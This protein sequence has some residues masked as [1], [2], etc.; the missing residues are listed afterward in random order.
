[1]KPLKELFSQY[2]PDAASLEFL[3]DSGDYSVARS[4]K[5]ADRYE[6]TV[7]PSRVWSKEL[8]GAVED[9]LNR[10]YGGRYPVR[11][12]T[13]YGPGLFGPA[14][15]D[16]AVAEAVRRGLIPPGF[17]GDCSF[18]FDGSVLD[19]TANVG[20]GGLDF[21]SANK[22][23][24]A[25]AA[26]IADEFS[27]Q[28]PVRITGRR[29]YVPYGESA[30]MKEFYSELD[31]KCREALDTYESDP[32]PAARADDRSGDAAPALRRVRS[33]F[34][35]DAVAQVSD[36]ICSIGRTSF[37]ISSPELLYGPDF[38]IEPV[39]VAS[40]AGP[41]RN[42]VFTGT[43][44]DIRSD[45]RNK[46][47]FLVSGALFDGNATVALR[48]S[49]CTEEQAAE[50]T[51]KL[52][53]GMTVAALGD[54]RTDT[55][56]GELY[57]SPRSFAKISRLPR[58]DT[59]E[60]KRVELHLHTSMSAMDAIPAVSDVIARAMDWGHGAVAITDHGNVQAFPD[61]MIY[62]DKYYAKH[63]EVP[64]EERFKPIYGMEAYFVKDTAVP[65]RGRADPDFDAPAVVFDLETTGLSASDS[66]IIEI[67]AVRLEHG[68]VTGRFST[69]VDPG[70]P[71]PKEITAITSIKDSDVAGAPSAAEAVPQ[72]LDFCSGALLVAHNA[73]FDVGFIRTAA[74]ELG[75][76]FDRPYLD[77]LALSR[78]LNPDLARHR[79]DNVAKYY[80]LGDFRHHRAVDDAEILSRIYLCMIEKMREFDIKDLAAMEREISTKS[81][82]LKLNSYHMIILVKNATGLKNLYR[83]IS[84]SYL[85]YYYRNPRIPKTLLD[86]Y[87]EGLIIGSA[88]SMGELYT[89]IIENRSEAEIEEIASYYDYLEIQ[90]ISNDMYMVGENKVESEETLRDVTRRIVALADKLGKP[91]VATSDAHFL[92]PDDEIYRRILQA[93]MK[94]RN[95]DTPMPLYFHTTDEMLREFDFLGPEKAYEVVVVNP[96]RIAESVGR[97]RPIPAGN[98]P[99][100]LEG[101]EEE[102]T[103]SCHRRAR[104]LYGD[105]LPAVVKN[106]LD[107]ELGSIIS[108]GFAV[109]YVIAARLVS[110]SESQGYLV[111][112]RG[113]VGS[114]FVAAMGGI[115]EVNALP[116]HYYCPSCKFSD[117]SNP[118]DAGSGFDFP[119]AV[120]PV[121]GA[122]LL[123]D[124][125]DIPFET[126][127]GFHGEK[128]PDIDLNFSGDVQGSVHR[129]TE[130]LFG[131][132]NVFKAGTVSTLADKTAYGFVMKYYENRGVMPPRAEIDRIVGRCMGV[133]RTTG[134]HPGGIIVVPRDRDVYDFTPVQRP[135]DDPRSD[136]V[137]THFAFSYLH[138]TILKLDELGHDVPT[139]YKYLE[140]YSGVPVLDVAMND[141]S[142]YELFYSTESIGIPQMD[143][144]DH[145]TRMLGLSVGTLGIPEMG[146]SFIQQVLMDA[147]PRNFADLIQVSGLTHGTDVW[148][149][150]AQDLIKQGICDI[151]HVVGTRDGIMLDLIRYGV[152]KSMAFKIMEKVRKNKKGERLPAEMLD[153]MRE[154]SVPEW[155]IGSLQKIKYMFPK[156]HAAAYIMSAIR[157]GW[158]KVHRPVAF[159]CAILT[160][161]PDGFDGEI[162]GAGRSVIENNL[163]RIDRLGKEATQHDEKMV[164]ALQFSNEAMLRGIRFLPVS[165][166][167]SSAYEFLPE[168]DSAIRMPFIALSGIGLSAAQSIVEARSREPFFSVD[169][170]RE[171]SKVSKAVIETLR[172]N[173]A[174][175]GLSESDQLS[176]F[177]MI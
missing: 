55:K 32:A 128:S 31:R 10:A 44:T 97:V 81:D 71:I 114:S 86:R 68:E 24:E 36:G 13:V 46:Q 152:E 92:D 9:G 23:A 165:L 67:G 133:K 145:R 74:E 16:G 56:S 150:N 174:L 87:R 158:Y 25:V 142:V 64:E 51:G 48:F 105:Y 119:D 135:A 60:Q 19:I 1:M 169:D 52:S 6:I 20:G 18:D 161:A 63:P 151:G 99:P 90:P 76:T 45:S 110:F 65:L 83:L 149:G 12:R 37:D 154:A 109:L 127:L 107:V 3:E 100:N 98:Y 112:S 111:G 17:L 176:V 21:L 146:T 91:C 143:T 89:A 75:L 94:F 62:L 54:V 27:V 131:S 26:V 78:F 8:I 130:E 134:Q 77:T 162:V 58:R 39:S 168:G 117:F 38:D 4:K 70:V 47:T 104:E 172:A 35:E 141:R 95:A 175:E 129:F 42:V 153:A 69:Y 102:L 101:A 156:A 173:G 144:D 43:L 82:P 124:G 103:E 137:T 122:K 80:G 34:D 118:W 108:H 113:S 167:K 140:K 41:A 96:N 115:S 139:K 126:F 166:T 29:D 123:A 120:C 72:F 155:Y 49:Q 33:V 159:Y 50:I 79:L 132:E 66:R 2:R 11:F 116:P 164:F 53:A 5:N 106:R 160:V 171:R 170:L 85:R 147:K 61:A 148:L 136:I 84:E 15:F 163:I 30:E 88:C 57:F 93:G 22:A 177:D 121:C 73:D 14:C 138:D 125:Q 7:Y 28:I 59:A 40:V 157:L